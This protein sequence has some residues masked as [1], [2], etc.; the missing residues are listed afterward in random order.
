MSCPVLVDIVHVTPL[1]KPLL[2]SILLATP[3]DGYLGGSDCAMPPVGVGVSLPVPMERARSGPPAD[4][5]RDEIEQRLGMW[6]D[7]KLRYPD[8]LRVRTHGDGWKVGQFDRIDVEVEGGKL[9]VVPLAYAKITFHGVA[10]DLA[11]LFSRGEVELSGRTPVE[12]HLELSEEGLNQV[13]ARKAHRLRVDAPRIELEDGQ[14]H[15]SGRMKTFVIKNDVLT[16]GRFT[17]NGSGLHYLP[18]ALKVG[19]LPLPQAALNALARRFNPIVD[20][21]RLKPLKGLAFHLDRVAIEGE[22]LILETAGGARIAK[23]E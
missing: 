19:Y 5:T 22:R 10:V 3:P 17:I 18:S 14:V 13:L 8:T 9:D 2:I 6:L 1:I 15:F 23:R 21:G 7:R 12:A 20:L 16:S 4:I 11:Q